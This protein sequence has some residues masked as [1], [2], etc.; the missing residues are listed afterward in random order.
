MRKKK[1]NKQENYKA[2]DRRRRDRMYK[3]DDYLQLEI[4]EQTKTLFEKNRNK[5]TE[6]NWYQIEDNGAIGE[7]GSLLGTPKVMKRGL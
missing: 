6:D 4:H 2:W 7:G 3:K 1:K 5:I